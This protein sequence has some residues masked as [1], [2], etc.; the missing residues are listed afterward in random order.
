MSGRV[1]LVLHGHMPYVLHHGAWPHGEQWL[2]EAAF[3][4]Y[5][6]LLELLSRRD[7]ALTLGLT[8]VLLAQL[9]SPRFV[10]GFYLYM[11]EQLRAVMLDKKDSDLREGALYWER[12]I[13]RR[14]DQFSRM[15]GDIVARFVFFAQKQKLE[16][17]SSFATHGYAPLLSRDES[18]AEQLAVGLEISTNLLGYTPKGIWLPECAFAPQ[19]EQGG[20]LRR[21]VD[22]ILEDAGVQFFYVEDQAFVHARSEGLVLDKRFYKVDWDAVLHEPQWAWR[23]LL[24]PHLISTVGDSSTIAAFAR[25]PELCA[26][27]WSADVG[28]PGDPLYLEFHKKSPHSGMRYWRVTDRELGMDSKKYYSPQLAQER[29]RLHA[30]H[31]TQKCADILHRYSQSGRNGII[32]CCFDAE[33]FGHWWH[34]GVHFL[35]ALD[36]EMERKPHVEMKTGSVL[37]RESPPDKVVWIP[38][39]SWGAQADHR[40][41]L[42]DHTTWM[43]KAIHNAEYR[44]H[45][46]KAEVQKL[47]LERQA[48]LSE[49]M[50]QFQWNFLLLQSSDWPFVITTKGAVDYGYRRF[51]LHLERFERLYSLIEKRRNRKPWSEQEH[52]AFQELC[53]YEER[54]LSSS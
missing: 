12:L 22:R 9:K 41:W 32:T 54:P 4:V 23:S 38:E 47:S 31:F 16:L 35:E 2:Y 20:R 49:I 34:E 1:Q 27:L 25:E 52:I 13:L 42:T 37:L 39:C 10:E 8:P 17:L 48:E 40:T 45:M 11:K 29:A 50:K 46:I 3:E 7:M 24:E 26:Q 14:L 53:L 30:F 5:L 15:N 33:L 18:I 51:S 44:Y 28:Y 21:G 43:W 36:V 19:R 6:P